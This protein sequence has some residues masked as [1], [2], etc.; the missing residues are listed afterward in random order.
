MMPLQTSE[1]SPRGRQ[2]SA[3]EVASCKPRARNAKR[4]SWADRDLEQC[5]G[6]VADAID[7]LRH[8]SNHRDLRRPRSA[9]HAGLVGR[10]RHRSRPRPPIVIS[11]TSEESASR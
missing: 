8:P 9:S 11:S 1:D 4:S 2:F 5:A 6:L 10:H 7:L 3:L